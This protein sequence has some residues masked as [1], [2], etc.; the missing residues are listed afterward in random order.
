MSAPLALPPDS[1]AAAQPVRLSLEGM[2]CATCA[3]RIEKVLRKVPGVA[4]VQVNLASEVA[5][6]A[7]LPGAAELSTLVAA[8]ERAGF[9][10][11]LAERSPGAA[12]EEAAARRDRRELAVLVGAALLT[13]PLIVPMVG[14]VVGRHWMLPGL[15]QLVLATPVQLVAGARFYSG[16]YNALRGGSANMDVLVAL[17]TSAAFLLSVWLLWQGEPHL[18]FEAAAAVVTLVRLGKW[19]ELRAKR[20]TNQALKA[21]LALRPERARVLREGR[22]VDVPAEAVGK[23]DVVVVRPGE[24]VPVDGR[25]VFGDTQVDESLITGEAMPVPRGPKDEV[26]AGAINVDGLIHLEALRVGEEST[27]NRII[28]L[29]QGAQG[30]RPPIQR[31]VDRVS[32]IFVPAVLAF[33]A[34]TFLGWWLAGAGLTAAIITAVSVLVIACPCALGLATP[35]ALVVGTGVAARAGVLIR[36]AEALE[37]AHVLDVVVFD[38]TGTLTEGRPELVTT[39]AVNGDVDGLLAH[40]AALQ[41]GSEHPLGQAV[42]RA[43]QAQALALPPVT[44]FRALPGRGVSGLV[45]GRELVVGSP[46]LVRERGVDVS[47]HA[48]SAFALEEE[49]MTVVWVFE[50]ER[51]LGYL[52]LADAPREGALEAVAGLREAGVETILLTGDNRAAAERMGALLGVDRV[53]AEVLPEDKAAEVSRLRAEGRVVGMVGDGVN[54]APALAAADVGLAMASGT[55]VAKKSAGVTL[56]RPDPRLVATAVAISRATT[57]KIRQNLFWAFFYNVIGLPLSAAGFLTPVFAGAAMALSSV[58]VLSNALL[59]RRFKPPR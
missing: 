53:L 16:A 5:T 30:T 9:G 42:V 23:G 27:I 2:T 41:H 51:I 37:R 43:A 29:V 19:L 59:L 45:E 15:A 10:A 25:V 20:S 54:D 33:A 3:T 8:V 35:A 1:R 44:G 36:D 12:T 28:A 24:R 32:S 49:G 47:A 7:V 18:Y 26:P 46:R 56:M 34:L 39:L 57:S 48:A 31:L 55:D 40:V 22:E 38:K 17:G 13:A 4:A 6:V 14:D 50:G 58:S 52:G 21:L 11:R